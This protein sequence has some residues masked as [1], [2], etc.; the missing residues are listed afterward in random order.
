MYPCIL[1][2]VCKASKVILSYPFIYIQ[3]LQFFSEV[4]TAH[5]V[6]TQKNLTMSGMFVAEA[7]AGFC[8]ILHNLKAVWSA[9]CI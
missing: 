6:H 1:Q 3:L 8:F 4:T 7:L 2:L 9:I 5:A